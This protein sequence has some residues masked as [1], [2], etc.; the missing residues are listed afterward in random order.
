MSHVGLFLLPN[1]GDF[2][3]QITICVT[4]FAAAFIEGIS[5]E[6][7]KMQRAEDLFSIACLIA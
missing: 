3:G 6:N 1:S 5:H 2:G 7:P 4:R